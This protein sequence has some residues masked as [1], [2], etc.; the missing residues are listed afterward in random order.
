MRAN[1]KRFVAFLALV[2]LAMLVLLPLAQAK[3]YKW[4]DEKG[5]V[6]YSQIPPPSQSKKKVKTMDVGTR[7]SGSGSTHSKVDKSYCNDVR[8]FS[9]SV[10]R[11]MRRGLS[12][13]QASNLT[14]ATDERL[15]DILDTN[16]P[17]AKQVIY[18]VYRY[19]SSSHS[20]AEISVLV[21]NQCLN[22]SFGGRE[23]VGKSSGRSA[24]TGWPVAAGYV[25][26]NQH[27]IA[28]SSKISIILY[29]GKKL[30]GKVISE[31]RKNDLVLIKVN[32]A[33]KLPPALPIAIRDGT[34]GEEVFTIGF[35]HTGVM[36]S[37]PKLTTG[38]ISATTG[39]KDDP[40]TYQISVPLQ[41][42]NSGGPLLN[43]RGEVVGVVTA[44]LSAMKVFRE[45]GDL[46]QN[47]NYAVKIKYLRDL[48]EQAQS[49]QGMRSLSA[50]SG[51]LAELAP[52]VEQSILMVVAE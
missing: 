44:K 45:T 34:I 32:N 11:A 6:H 29:N 52:D 46:P 19:K 12:A 37:K 51:S 2:F 47:V 33:Q 43:M 38:H 8:K 48:L 30:E 26:T 17:I 42:G 25:V 41:S 40:R 7:R 16:Q 3:I 24:G 10:A 13:A 9:I 1:K 27:V 36:G 35:P 23:T 31:D 22:G 50:K 14:T 20:A 39:I 4:T 15:K 21:F 28:G 5:K 18:Y 49:I